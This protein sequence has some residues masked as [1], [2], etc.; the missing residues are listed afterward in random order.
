VLKQLDQPL[1]PTHASRLNQIE[2]RFSILSRQALQGTS[3]TSAQGL[4]QAIA[5][6][7]DS[8]HSRA[9]PFEWKTAKVHSVHPKPYYSYLRH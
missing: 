9:L 2:C 4:R 3:F 7:I 6:F 1:T 8:Y 5:P